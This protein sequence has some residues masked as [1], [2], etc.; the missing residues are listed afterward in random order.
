[1]LD[2]LA[3]D[4]VL[5][6]EADRRFGRRTAVLSPALL[7]AQGWRAAALGGRPE[8][9]GWHGN[10]ILVRPAVTIVSQ[11]VIPLPVLEPRGA[12]MAELAL[13]GSRLRLVGM[14]LD[15][16]G[17][18]RRQQ[19]DAI[20]A[21]L[22]RATP[23]L[24]VLLAGD[25]N[26]WWPASA[27]IAGFCRRHCEI[28]FPPSF[29]ALYPLARLDRAFHSADLVVEAAGVHQSALAR[30]ASDHL[31]LWIDLRLPAAA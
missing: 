16:S 23:A 13:A 9:L 15:L 11:S 5:L 21:A 10:A 6:Q 1:M 4:V 18:R 25:M 28:R 7:A 19:G 3:A 12:V 17:L 22:D 29:P 24:P 2:E 8:S 30:M 27:G 26:E 20:L 31:P 14:H